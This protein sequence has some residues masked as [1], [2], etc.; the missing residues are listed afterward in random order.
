MAHNGSTSGIQ[1]TEAVYAD[2]VLKPVDRLDLREH[3]R[4]RVVVQSMR[5]PSAEARTAALAELA[6]GIERMNFRSTRPY[7]TRDEL[8]ERR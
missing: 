7:P 1:V 8:H 2:G 6:A 4:V 5:R 3:E